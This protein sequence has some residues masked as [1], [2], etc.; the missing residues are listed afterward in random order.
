MQTKNGS[1]S[2]TSGPL[3]IS[4]SLFDLLAAHLLTQQ[5]IGGRFCASSDAI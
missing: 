3:F 5:L 4:A 1:E 2:E